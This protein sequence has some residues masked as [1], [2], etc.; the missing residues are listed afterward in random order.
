MRIT[1]PGV[2][3]RGPC[4]TISFEG[5]D[6]RA[7]RGESIAAALLSAGIVALRETPRGEVRGAGRRVGG[8]QGFE[9]GRLGVR[10]GAVEEP[11][12]EVVGAGHGGLNFPSMQARRRNRMRDTMR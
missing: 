3:R 8:D 1:T 5:V 10:Q 7:W 4:F 9:F 12:G 11:G 6:V 2:A